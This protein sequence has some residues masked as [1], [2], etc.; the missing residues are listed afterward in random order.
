ML[1]AAGHRAW[2][3]TPKSA[4]CLGTVVAVLVFMNPHVTQGQSQTP[5]ALWERE[6]TVC[7]GGAAD[8]RA[9]SRQ[10]LAM[11]P[12]E[13][14]VR[15]L[16]TGAMREQGATLSD[17]QRRAMAE[18]LAGRAVS[19]AGPATWEGCAESPPM[20]DPKAL[21]GWNGWGVTA[22]NTRFQPAAQAGLN[23]A[24]VPKLTLRWA[25]GFPEANQAWS[26]PVVAAGRLFIGSQN[27]H[28]YALDARTGCT[29]WIFTAHSAVRS[30]ISVAP[31]GD[32]TYAAFFGDMAGTV[33][34]VDASTGELV[35]STRVDEHP[36]ARI[37]G[38]PTFFAGRLF[39]PVSSLEEA[40]GMIPGYECCQFRGSVVA[41]DAATGRVIWKTYTLDEP[42]PIGQMPT[43]AQGWGPSGAAI[44][45]APTVDAERGV[46]YAATGNQYTGPE[47]ETGDAVIALNMND[48]G[49]KWAKQLLPADIF[50]GG[51]M[52]GGGAA[53][54]CPDD[55]GPDYDFGNSPMLVSLP[56]GGDLIVIGQK[57]GM[58]WAIDPDNEGEVVW[59]YPAGQ[60]GLNGGMEWGSAA[61]SELAY[62]PVSDAPFPGVPDPD[63]PEP[64]GL[65]AVR[66]DTGER[67]WY[68]PPIAPVCDP[69]PGCNAGQ[70]AAITVIPGVVF[71]G[72]NDGALR[73]YDTHDGRVIWEF[74]SNREFETVN[75]VPAKGA[76]MNGAGPAIVDGMLYVNSGY[77][78]YGVSRPGNVLLAFGVE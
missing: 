32:A 12:P 1:R 3:G 23:A 65:H 29:H 40:S 55:A 53:P 42:S 62:F 4:A 38:A 76:S 46:I 68:A 27:G 15:S 26:Q 5:A 75:G 31:R 73:A 20:S 8:S 58:G 63:P 72:S 77:F 30:A 52:T 56:A 9:P 10:T 51:C 74:D 28:V 71:S 7:H 22:T 16:T 2:G 6:C 41:M 18:Y 14:I 49:V 59:Q 66:L 13:A 24:D 70:I 34:A 47:R 48:G 69:G 19:D 54:L 25:F 21:P 39:V 57:S 36:V 50:G 33:Y 60:G 37:T 43:G 17:T 35:W 61:D 44:W 64:G 67:V 45:G 78:G 11:S